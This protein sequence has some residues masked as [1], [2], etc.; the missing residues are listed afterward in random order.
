MTVGSL[1]P[2]P[3]EGLTPP[4]IIVSRVNLD[5]R[6]PFRI[7]VFNFSAFLTSK[8]GGVKDSWVFAGTFSSSSGGSFFMTI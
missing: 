6:T 4:S 2:P 7:R 8:G 1:A 3:T 5:A